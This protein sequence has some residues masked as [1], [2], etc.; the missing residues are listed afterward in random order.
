V[1]GQRIPLGYRL[2][3]R[4]NKP[5][6]A[7][8]LSLFALA[9]GLSLGVGLAVVTVGGSD[10]EEFAP[11][12]VPLAGPFIALGTL[13]EA[14]AT[15]TLN[16]ITQT[17]GLIMTF[18]GIFATEQVLVRIDAPVASATPEILIGPGTAG[19]RWQF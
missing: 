7:S 19:A 12:L 6:I 8:G 10:S 18:I 16:G 1:D 4:S 13:P 14:S 2:E 11:L 15:M 17:A 3:E 9:Y 5:L